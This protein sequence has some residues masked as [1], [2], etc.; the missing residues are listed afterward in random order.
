MATIASS[1]STTARGRS[2][3]PALVEAVAA[4][5]AGHGAAIPVVPVAETLK[6]I[7]GESGRRRR[8]TGR[9]SATAQT[10]AGRPARPAPRRRSTAS[11]RTARTCSPTR[12]PCS[13]PVASPSMSSPATRQPQGDAARRPRTRRG[14]SCRA[15]A[16]DAHGDRPRQP[17]VR[18]GRRRS[19]LGGDRDRRARRG[20][21]ATPTATS[22]STRSPTRCSA[23]RASATS[24]ASSRP[25]RRRRAASPARDLLAEVVGAARGRR[26]A[27]GLGRPDDRRRPAAA[28]RR[29]S[30]RCATRSRRLLGLDAT[31]VNVKA[32][33]GNLAGVGGRRPG[34]LGA[35]R[36]D[37]RGGPMTHPAARHADAA[38]RRPL[39]PLDA[40]RVAHLLLRP[41]RL[42]PGPHRQLPLVPVR[43]PARPPPAL[44]RPAR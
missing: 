20:S 24:A 25:D 26:L 30:T 35:R 7:D 2:S 39:E 41:D 40:E 36:R 33:T 22:R 1:S 29:A 42:R 13:R 38:R 37:A 23:R 9:S 44:A 15:P 10:P 11:R 32:S 43:R 16:A 28:R 19:R 3:S 6:R 18:A 31:R 4:A 34:D 17:P 21:T 5:A 12:P 27:A 14:R 8:S